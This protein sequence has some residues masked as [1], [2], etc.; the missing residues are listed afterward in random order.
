M[1]R[2]N[3]PVIPGRFLRVPHIGTD[4]YLNM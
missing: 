3:L 2:I 4:T 1:K